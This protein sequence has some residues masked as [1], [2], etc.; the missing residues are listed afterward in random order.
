M[1]YLRQVIILVPDR[2]VLAPSLA[3]T[4]VRDVSALQTLVLLPVFSSP[5][6][7]SA[8]PSLLAVP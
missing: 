2:S 4:V 8:F 5:L 7:E 3:F 6:R 1:V